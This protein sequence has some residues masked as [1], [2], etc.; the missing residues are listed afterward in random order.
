MSQEV[1]NP[2][3]MGADV[4][5]VIEDSPTLGGASHRLDAGVDQVGGAE[6]TQDEGGLDVVAEAVAKA[7]EDTDLNTVDTNNGS[8]AVDYSWRTDIKPLVKEGTVSLT[9]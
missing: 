7:G 1:L 9:S 6:T 5:P 3:E 2:G 4:G 8:G